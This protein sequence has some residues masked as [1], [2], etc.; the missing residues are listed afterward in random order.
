MAVFYASLKVSDKADVST[1]QNKLPVVGALKFDKSKNEVEITATDENVM[2]RWANF[3]SGSRSSWHLIMGLSKNGDD[4]RKNPLGDL[5]R[6][7][8][9]ESGLEAFELGESG[10]LKYF[11]A[12]SR[13]N[14]AKK[15]TV[16]LVTW[17]GEAPP[18]E[19]RKKKK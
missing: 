3:F 11:E 7:G 17:D 10:E 14:G 6:F 18:P 4:F 12:L 1:P 2:N 13:L 5:D 9:Y 19:P 8:F 15:K 16:K